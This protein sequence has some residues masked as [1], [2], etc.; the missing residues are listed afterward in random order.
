MRLI[1]NSRGFTLVELLLVMAI[2]GILAAII[3][4]TIGPARKK[5]RI[6]TF[7]QHMVDLA[8]A[9]AS[10]IDSDGIIQGGN[11]DDSQ[12]FCTDGA[13]NAVGGLG[14]IPTIKECKGGSNTI[15][16]TVT[17]GDSDDF[18]LDASCPVSGTGAGA[19]SCD[20]HCTVNGCTFTDGCNL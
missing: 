7:K 3:F 4:V 18:Q 6:T 13:G 1:N 14:N 2:I 17:D 8:T 15:T 9:G 16:I 19:V 20:A 10:C 11:A 5:A 12:P